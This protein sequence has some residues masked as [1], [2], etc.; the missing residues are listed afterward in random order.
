MKDVTTKHQSKSE[1]RL[2]LTPWLKVSEIS[3]ATLLSF[4]RNK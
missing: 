3:P 2:L 4:Y 1:T